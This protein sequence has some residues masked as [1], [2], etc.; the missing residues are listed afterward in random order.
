MA[1]F[2][3]TCLLGGERARGEEGERGVAGESEREMQGRRTMRLPSSMSILL[4]MTTKGKFSG[5]RGEAWGV[6]VA[7]GGEEDGRRMEG[8]RGGVAC[9]GEEL[10]LSVG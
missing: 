2:W 10:G 4:P 1:R 7:L 8:Q 3:E 9:R 6:C 5:S